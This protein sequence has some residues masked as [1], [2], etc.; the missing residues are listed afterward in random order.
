MTPEQR[1]MTLELNHAAAA[2][3]RAW[4]ISRTTKLEHD[5]ERLLAAAKATRDLVVAEAGR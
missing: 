3:E 2:I 1:I 4:L 5:L